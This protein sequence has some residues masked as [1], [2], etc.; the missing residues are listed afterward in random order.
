MRHGIFGI[1]KEDIGEETVFDETAADFTPEEVIAAEEDAAE[2]AELVGDTQKSVDAIEL[3]ESAQ[4]EVEESIVDQTEMLANPAEITATDVVVAQERLEATARMLG[5]SLSELEITT[6]S[7]ENLDKSPITGLEVSLENAKDMVLNIIEQIKVVF[8]KIMVNIKKIYVKIVVALNR[9][10]AYADSLAKKVNTLKDGKDSKFTPEQQ[11]SLAGRLAV[12]AA[13]AGGHLTDSPM[14]AIKEFL[15]G[16]SSS[17]YTAKSEKAIDALFKAVD[18][19]VAGG[20]NSAVI[21]AAEALNKVVGT[22]LQSDVAKFI[23]E[24]PDAFIGGNV[25]KVTGLYRFDGSSIKAIVVK[26][27]EEKYKAAVAAGELG[28]ASAASVTT[29]ATLKFKP[30]YLKT[31]KVDVPTKA[32]VLAM[33]KDV[34]AAAGK[35]K[36]F[37]DKTM[38]AIDAT[39]KA[40]DKLAAMVGKQKELAGES[41]AAVSIAVKQ[42]RIF[43]V[44]CALESILGYV[45]AVKA[46]L[47]Y[48]VTASSTFEK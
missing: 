26:I 5:T 1:S 40:M 24:K 8:K 48:C 12:P 39:D 14:G 18:A 25:G 27:D 38:G 45:G 44:G 34:K 32:A 19:Q 31:V 9:S 13:L 17:D 46:V 33:L 6:V 47:G 2:I 10:G 35:I 28:K 43:V 41:K 36:P 15:D 37:A 20:E 22:K 21:T 11:L 30:E 3:A 7:R 29:T 23:T 42:G 4:D 16:V